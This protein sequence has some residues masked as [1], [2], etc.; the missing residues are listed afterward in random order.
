MVVVVEPGWQGGA[1]ALFA[2]VEPLVGPFV[3]QGA[4]EPFRLPV[5]LWPVGSGA[6]VGD[7]ERGQGVAPGV[8]AVAG[9]VEFLTDVK[10][11]GGV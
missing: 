2:G 4:V 1:P 5:G 6:Q 11:P 7:A 9:S 3:E 10:R 8:G